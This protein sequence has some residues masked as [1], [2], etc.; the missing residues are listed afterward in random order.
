MKS[1]FLGLI[2]R[3]R[4]LLKWTLFFVLT[5]LAL[6]VDLV[7]KHIAE[8]RLVL[9]E[10]HEVLPFLSLQLTQNDGVAFGLLG[11]STTVIVIA[12]VFAMLIVALYVL[13]ERRPVFGGI[14]G[15]AVLGGSLGN[16]IQRLSGDGHVTDFLKF[17][18]WPNFNAADVF[19]DVGLAALVIGVIVELVRS[20]RE[21][22]HNIE[23]SG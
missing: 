17:P 1:R 13:L 8:D 14:V 4:S 19:I 7:T 5:A 2:P 3:E 12:N 23:S 15:G 6:T 9:G 10:V 20:W 22:K 16:F 21:K 18:S 11:G